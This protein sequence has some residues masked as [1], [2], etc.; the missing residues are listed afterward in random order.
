MRN[1]I[2]FAAAIFLFAILNGCAPERGDEKFYDRHP[3]YNNP[4]SYFEKDPGYKD[5][6]P[7]ETS[8]NTHTTAQ[9]PR[10]AEIL[11]VFSIA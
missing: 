5:E 2:H 1:V 10:T 11:P 9:W 4:P 8:N 7:V 3:E 6:I